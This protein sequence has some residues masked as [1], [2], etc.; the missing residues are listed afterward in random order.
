MLTPSLNASLFL[1]LGPGSLSGQIF[2]DLCDQLLLREFN[3]RGGDFWAPSD[4]AGDYKGLDAYVNVDSRQSFDGFTGK[5]GFQYKFVPSEASPLSRSHKDQIISSLKSAIKENKDELN[6]WILIT[7][8]DFNK[9]QIEWLTNLKSAYDCK[10]EIKHWGQKQLASLIAKYP[11]LAI[12]IY[13][14][15]ASGLVSAN[16]HQMCTRL[17]ETLTSQPEL[18]TYYVPLALED[19][20]DVGQA[21]I[22]FTNNPNSLLFCLLGS[23]GTGKTTVLEQLS[24]ILA[25]HY[26]QDQTR[27][28]PLLIRLR[29]VRG[30]SSFRHNLIHYI[31][32][33]Y[34]I[35]I[36]IVTLQNLNA[37]GRLILIFDGLDEKED[38]RSRK[39]SRTKLGEVFEFLSP[40]GKLI[41]S[42]RTEFFTEAV[43]ERRAILGYQRPHVF[44]VKAKSVRS[45]DARSEITYLSLLTNSQIEVYVKRRVSNEADYLLSRI[46]SIYDLR[47]IIRRAI[48]LN[49]VCDTVPYLN[50]S[51]NEILAT[52]LY[53]SYIES[54]LERDATTERITTNLHGRLLAISK[55]AEYML[56]NNKF[57]IHY[58]IIRK[59]IA[60]P[61]GDED[62][63]FLSTSFLI[64]DPNGYYEFSHRSFLEYFG[65]FHM[66]L[67]LKEPHYKSKLWEQPSLS[68][69]EQWNFLDQM[70][71]SAW[72][73]IQKDDLTDTDLY[74][75]E[76]ELLIER[77]PV[78]VH[79]FESFV[80]LTGY[81][82]LYIERIDKY[83]A[84]TWYDAVAYS[85]WKAG[86]ILDK[87][88]LIKLANK[89]WPHSR[90]SFNEMPR[91]SIFR[92]IDEEW[93]KEITSHN[94]VVLLRGH[95]EWTALHRPI[96]SRWFY[97]SDERKLTTYYVNKK[98]VMETLAVFRCAYSPKS[99]E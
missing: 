77:S 56:I 31:R 40:Q 12:H 24:A 88:E 20:R 76:D 49:M 37:S 80:K 57:R 98:N 63:D 16:F 29:H 42:S 95:R 21:L 79:Q 18:T 17:V 46:R 68:T 5:I 6:A 15:L 92:Y 28:I 73:N 86:R 25:R 4:R 13:P 52:D 90:L 44:M 61:I 41:V 58:D 70:V 75:D 85:F 2:A 45:L 78:T 8:E 81:I 87:D 93:K 43:E 96:D 66:L 35:N 33:E 50:D 9:S 69:S 1:K 94:G 67:A 51:E 74:I 71:K 54:N 26:C 27:R 36:D 62:R 32:N 83:A 10:F 84:V 65:A 47:D 72:H 19:G 39:L 60:L 23:Y 64:R 22:D 59:D 7:P 3:M 30:D 55:I 11:E 89:E 82:P 99:M 53:Q 97:T 14:Q 38:S 91:N 48:M 34:G